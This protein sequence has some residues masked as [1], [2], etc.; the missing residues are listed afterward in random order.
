MNEKLLTFNKI[1]E[2][3]SEQLRNFY[4]KYNELPKKKNKEETRLQKN[5]AYIRITMYL[6][7]FPYF[8]SFYKMNIFS[9]FYM[10]PILG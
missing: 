4:N 3:F 8:M 5:K 1:F 9:V 2:D 6:L 10:T 7:Q